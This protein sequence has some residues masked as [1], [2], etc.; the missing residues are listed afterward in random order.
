MFLAHIL[1]GAPEALP[2][3]PIARWE[4]VFPVVEAIHICGFTLL[5]GS[6]VILDFRL[7]GICL[8]SQPVSRLARELSPWVWAGIALQLTTGPYLFSADPHEYVQIAAFR[9]KMLFLL[10]V[11]IFQFTVIRK[12]TAPAADSAPLGW[13]RPAACVSL[14]L[15]FCV[16]LAGLWIGNL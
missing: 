7:L 15:W 4:W 6:T 8:R 2:L 9:N 3:N 13:R 1:Q 5:V 16:L 10:L 12:A 14:G 11:L